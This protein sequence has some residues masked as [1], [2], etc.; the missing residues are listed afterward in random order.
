MW[1]EETPQERLLDMAIAE[2]A[3]L[4]QTVAELRAER[5]RLLQSLTVIANGPPT[6]MDNDEVASWAAHLAL[7]ALA[8]PL[9]A[10][11]MQK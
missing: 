10:E 7:Y 3:T 6:E 9:A 2:I 11:D 8:S 1:T 4:K 5:E